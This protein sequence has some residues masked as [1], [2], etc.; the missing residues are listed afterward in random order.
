MD[1]PIKSGELA[2][3]RPLPVMGYTNQ[4]NDK[5]AMVNANKVF[6]ERLLRACDNHRAL[7]DQVDQRW[8]SIAIT[9]FQEGFMAL[10]RAV[11]QPT[12]ITLPEDE[13]S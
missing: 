4:S 8:V 6:E 5:L 3:H 2:G 10:N 11:F 13:V 7:G 9:H 12:R 1:H